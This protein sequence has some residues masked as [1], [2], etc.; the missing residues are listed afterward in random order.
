MIVKYSSNPTRSVMLW[1]KRVLIPSFKILVFLSVFLVLPQ[2]LAGQ[3]NQSLNYID[4]YII[5]SDTIIEGDSVRFNVDQEAIESSDLFYDTLKNRAYR[6]KL[7]QT[8]HDFLIVN[9]EEAE[10]LNQ[11]KIDNI[12]NPFNKYK[13]KT[14]DSIFITQLN[15]FGTSVEDTSVL[16]VS[17]Y[18]EF[19]NWFHISSREYIIKE[20]LLFKE[21]E[22][23]DPLLLADNERIL[24]RTQYLKDARII[25]HENK[26]DTGKVNVAVITQD[27]WSKGYNVNMRSINKGEVELFDNNIFGIGHKLQTDLVFDYLGQDNLGFK[28]FYRVDNLLGTFISGRFFYQDVFGDHLYG[29]Q[30]SRDFFSYKTNWV[31]GIRAL[32]HKTRQN[33]NKVDTTLYHVP[34]EY[35]EHDLWLGYAIPLDLNG[36]IFKGRNRLVLSA[37]YDWDI[38]KKGPEVDERYNY[39]YR[40]N[41]TALGKISFSR[42]NFYKSSLIYGFGRTEDIPVGDLIGYTFGWEKDEYFKRF[43]S[44]I[45]L[46]HGEYFSKLGY[47]SNSIDLGGFFYEKDFEQGVLSFNSKY[48]SKLFYIKDWKF[49]QFVDINYKYGIDRFPDE[50]IIFNPARDIRGYENGNLYGD[51]KLVLKLETV[52]FSNIYY[53]GFR[54]AFYGFMDFGFIGPEKRII[55]NNPVQSGFGLGLRIRNENLVFNTFQLRFG[56]YPNLSPGSNYLFRISGE[57]TLTP[58]RYTPSA[59]QVVE[60]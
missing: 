42:E 59:P 22:K 30:F 3:G 21:G 17:W 56:Y 34:M 6:N 45:S 11:D 49:R 2:Y 48:I 4:N 16:D 15:V 23:L 43:Y 25:V 29:F 37:R 26:A 9:P 14:I 7:L 28:G 27:V 1:F 18:K 60:F 52:G 47:F 24:R 8:I 55:F 10:V 31:G 19:A 53:Y 54:F 57:K 38:F 39:N 36:N 12:R 5:V 58:Y 13:G 46:K 20:N 35:I 40:D 44:G 50:K 32:R 41:Y 33:I 51:K